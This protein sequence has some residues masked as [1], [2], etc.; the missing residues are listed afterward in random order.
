MPSKG[1]SNEYIGDAWPAVAP[2]SDPVL[3]G[4]VSLE[5][6]GAFEVRSLQTFTM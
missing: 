1:V 4:H 5:P 3:Y 2:G 6:L